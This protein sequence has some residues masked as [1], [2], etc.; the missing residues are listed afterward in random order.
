MK[1]VLDNEYGYKVCYKNKHNQYVHRFLT[2]TYKQAQKAKNNYYK[3]PPKDIGDMEI[4]AYSNISFEV[5]LISHF[6]KC[7]TTLQLDDYAGELDKLLKKYKCNKTYSKSDENLLKEQFI[8]KYKTA[9]VNSKIIYQNYIKAHNEKNPNQKPPI[10]DWIS[11]T[12]VYKLVEA[13]KLQK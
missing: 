4:K 8:P 10:W 7:K 2:K 13:L 9:I 6:E 1:P 11:S 12:T 5:W 3:Y